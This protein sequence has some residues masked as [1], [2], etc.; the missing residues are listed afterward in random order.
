VAAEGN[1]SNLAE[2]L[3][4]CDLVATLFGAAFF[5]TDFGT[6]FGAIF[7]GAAFFTGLGV[8]CFDATFLTARFCAGSAATFLP[9]PK[10]VGRFRDGAGFVTIFFAAT[11]FTTCFGTGFLAIVFAAITGP[12]VSKLTLLLR[13]GNPG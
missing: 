1:G 12:V 9:P 7:F 11:F 5:T 3:L 8:T 4:A 13:N 10:N 6:G 2:A